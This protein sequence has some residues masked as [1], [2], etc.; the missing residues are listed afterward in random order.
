MTQIPIYIGIERNIHSQ[1]SIY[2][3]IYIYLYFV[4]LEKSIIAG[5]IRN[6]FYSC[7]CNFIIL[8]VHYI[9]FSYYKV[10]IIITIVKCFSFLYFAK[11]EFF[12]IFE[13]I[14]NLYKKINSFIHLY[15]YNIDD[16]HEII[17]MITSCVM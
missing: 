16:S 4:L 14:Y 15:I 1:L 10:I 5:I 13:K 9:L 7:Y 11:K 3:E 12:I 6:M 8:F 17:K 2:R